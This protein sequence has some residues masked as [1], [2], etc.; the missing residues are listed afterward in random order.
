MSIASLFRPAS[1]V[2]PVGRHAAPDTEE[3]TVAP[4]GGP[5]RHA[6]ED[7]DEQASDDP[8]ARTDADEDLLDSLGF[9]YEA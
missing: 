7:D 3:R 1:L 8:Q 4:D 2:V 6:A 9:A 5:G